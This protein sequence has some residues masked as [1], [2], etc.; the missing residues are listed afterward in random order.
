MLPE[1]G[2]CAFKEGHYAYFL[3][4]IGEAEPFVP[5]FRN[6]DHARAYADAQGRKK[7]ARSNATKSA[8]TKGSTEATP[9]PAAKRGKGGK[10]P[11]MNDEAEAEAKAEVKPKPEARDRKKPKP[12]PEAK[13]EPPSP[14]SPPPPPPPPTAE[15]LHR[16]AEGAPPPRKAAMAARSELKEPSDSIR[17]LTQGTEGGRARER[18]VASLDAMRMWV[19]CETPSCGKWRVV[20]QSTD[21]DGW[22]CLRQ[23]PFSHDAPEDKMDEDEMYLDSAEVIEDDALPGWTVTSRT[24]TSGRVYKSFTTPQGTI[25]RSR[26][27]ALAAAA[28]LARGE[29]PPAGRPRTSSGG[30]GETPRR[31]RAGS[32]L[33]LG[34]AVRALAAAEA[35]AAAE[36]KA[37]AEAEGAVAALA[38]GAAR[39]ASGGG[40]GGD[41]TA[42]PP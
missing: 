18:S 12:K 41:G 10:E 37:A 26:V 34:T 1:G 22:T 19:Q 35:E 24:T 40:G 36:A 9:S 38:A 29:R 8:T 6:I 3:P 31:E 28:A 5:F 30:G 42:L 15:E 39:R 21:V 2:E 4:N 11:L 16:L 20:T 32:A 14:P 17:S 7:R 13:P 23:H 33:A 27:T 25:Y